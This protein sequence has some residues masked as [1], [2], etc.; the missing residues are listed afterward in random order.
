MVNTCVS[1]SCGEELSA[2]RTVNVWLVAAAVAAPVMTPAA[3]NESPAGR[4]PLLMLKVRGAV[5]PVAT[6]VWL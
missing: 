6:T 1:A 2:T 4:L 5:P 3:L